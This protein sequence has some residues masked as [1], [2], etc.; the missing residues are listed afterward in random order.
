ML[1][2]LQAAGFLL[3]PLCSSMLALTAAF[4]AVA[5]SWNIINT[6]GNTYVLWI[7]AEAAAAKAARTGSTSTESSS[8]LINTVNAAFGAGSLAAPVVAE[9]CATKMGQPLAAYWI[10]SALTALSAVTFLLL[11]SPRPPG[12]AASNSGSNSGNQQMPAIATEGGDSSSLQ[13]P[14]LDDSSTAAAADSDAAV[15]I[16][17][18]ADG[19]VAGAAGQ[20]QQADWWSGT[21]LLLLGV[22]ALFN[23]LNVGT[24]GEHD[25]ARCMACLLAC[26]LALSWQGPQLSAAAVL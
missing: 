9:L 7:A 13:Q 23:L 21:L 11:P 26:L 2:C 25:F 15:E 5:L 4:G 10:T 18:A 22:T 20:Q 17:A 12:A 14:L 1:C 6:A 24:E 8:V 19:A 3:M 16:L